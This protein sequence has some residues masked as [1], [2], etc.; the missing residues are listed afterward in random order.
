MI[1]N[2]TVTIFDA[3]L[4]SQILTKN[5][6]P[7]MLDWALY[8]SQVMELRVFPLPKGAKL[9][10]KGTN[11]F[12]D[13]TTDKDTIINWW[14]KNPDAN[15][16]IATGLQAN[17][18]FLTVVD[19]DDN[20]EKG[21]NGRQT[22]RDWE[23]NNGVLPNTLVSKT[24]SG[25]LHCL[26]WTNEEYRNRTGL[27]QYIDVRGEGGYIVAPPSVHPNGTTYQWVTEP[28]AEAIQSADDTVKKLLAVKQGKPVQPAKPTQSKAETKDLLPIQTVPEG[29]R[30]DT[31]YR[32]G[33]S[34]QAKGY[35]DENIYQLLE[36]M[37]AESCSPPLDTQEIE[38][39]LK[40]V[41][42][43]PKGIARTTEAAEDFEIYS[44]ELPP[45]IIPNLNK[46]EKITYTVNTPLLAKYVKLHLD[47]F[48]L[49]TIGKNPVIFVYN[50]D[51]GVYELCSEDRFKG[52]IG[53]FVSDFDES[54]STAKVQRDA[55]EK[56]KTYPDLANRV[57]VSQLNSDPN[58]INF[59]NGIL[60]L[61]TMELHPHDPKILSTI[62]IPCYWFGK[63][64]ATGSPIFT[65]YLNTLTSGDS[66]VIELLWQCIGLTIS[67]I[68]GYITKS[69]IFLC[70]AG[71]TGKSKYILLLQNILGEGNYSPAG[72]KS[73]EG[74]YIGS[75][76]FNKRLVGAA[77]LPF[78]KVT[79]LKTFKQMTGG[80][81]I[82]IEYKYVDAFPYIF[83]GVLLF[84]C[85]EM[86]HFDGDKGDHV[87]DRIIEVPC[88]NVIPEEKQDN[89]IV[90]KMYAER[91]EIVY[92][93]V[94]A[95]KR[96]IENGCRF[97]IPAVCITQREKYKTENDN[98]R[99]FVDEC[100][101]P[102]VTTTGSTAAYKGSYTT[103]VIYQAY[104]RWCEENNERKRSAREFRKS[105]CQKFG[106][107]DPTKLETKQ[108][109]N[110]YYSFTLNEEGRKYLS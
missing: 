16:G 85:N 40:S 91:E 88:K 7:T 27:L 95:L 62:Q 1:E 80:D 94:M 96:F 103:G 77:D 4:C 86:P 68:P 14:T 42:T 74:R 78:E 109:G 76:I 31:L 9:P 69:S 38:N 64:T 18:L 92:L 98:I 87:Y 84:G 11:G 30:N 47:Y 35:S 67:N 43:L 25:G 6:T 44:K 24:G 83:T 53:Q 106:V 108:N 15:I 104:C 60:H 70:G 50:Y 8:Y 10:Y 21:K 107:D 59:E 20:K 101:M 52:I 79:E 71:N 110:R 75:I 72:L 66:E 54:L 5:K 46:N 81:W 17:G 102:R 63:E 99:Q 37:N 89:D 12:K 57:N 41:L 45:F 39:I 13:A 19:I 58:L 32:Y 56:V 90:T 26:Y 82:P 33:C 49:D 61:D 73:L 55:Y 22:I 97:K 48:F 2:K 34:L 100:T 51:R 28:T 3:L 65:D 36:N 93:A 105:L 29:Q 23:A